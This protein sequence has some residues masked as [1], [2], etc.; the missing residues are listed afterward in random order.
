MFDEYKLADLKVR[1]VYLNNQWELV[2]KMYS[3]PN[4]CNYILKLGTWIMDIEGQI[5]L[6]EEVRATLK[7]A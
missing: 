3:N 7:Q 2:D 6:M 4:R 5:A 1:L